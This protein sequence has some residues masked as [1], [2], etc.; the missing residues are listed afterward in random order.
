MRTKKVL[1]VGAILL[2]ILAL[3]LL[4]SCSRPSLSQWVN[5]VQGPGYT[6]IYVTQANGRFWAIF[7]TDD[8]QIAICSSVQGPSGHTKIAG[9]RGEDVVDRSRS[10]T[11]LQ[12]RVTFGIGTFSRRPDGI[13]VPIRSDF[14]GQI[15]VVQYEAREASA[16]GSFTPDC[17]VLD[18]VLPWRAP[19]P[20]P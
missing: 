11:I 4:I 5:L 9:A 12:R 8:G 18:V 6:P 17:K 10:L 19:R 13:A 7:A 14:E 3:G 15:R 2:T 1:V 20:S 16:D